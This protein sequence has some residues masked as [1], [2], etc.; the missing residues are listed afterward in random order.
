[1]A[2]ELGLWRVDGPTPVRVTSRGMAL[3]ADLEALIEADPSILRPSLLIVGRQVLTDQ[4][5]FIDL[6][7]I[8]DEGALHVV[9]LKRDRTPREVVAQLLDYGSWVQSLT[10]QQVRDLYLLRNGTALEQA[11][12]DAFGTNPPDELNDQHHLT[13][14]A[15]ELDPATERIIGYLAD[16]DVPI[17]ALFFRYFTDGDRAYLGRTWLLKDNTTAP[18]TRP[19]RRAGAKEPWNEQDWYVSFGEETPGRSWD[20]ARKYGFVSAGG[21]AWFSRTLRKLPVGAR[22]FACIPSKGYVGVGTVTATAEPFDTATVTVD[23]QPVPLHEQPLTGRYHHPSATAVDDAQDYV[24]TI[25]WD[26]TV[27]R[28]A[29]VWEKGMFAN[30][31]SAC[32]LRNQ[33]TLD[34]LAES[35][36]LH[37][38]E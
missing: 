2:I 10:D 33:F 38:E 14:V 37:A 11:W 23:G 25:D 16:R 15:H 12:S 1:M 36:G 31:N 20:D 4:G 28:S 27:D 7:A 9:E 8:D 6:L 22:V 24:V 18:P 35:F 19:A 32:K 3:E 13:V 26:T 30:Q 29:A 5:Q 21:G 17:D 34:R